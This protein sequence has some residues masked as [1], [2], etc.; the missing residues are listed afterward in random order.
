MTKFDDYFMILL[1][2]KK[3]AADLKRIEMTPNACTI[4]RFTAVI[5][6]YYVKIPNQDWRDNPERKNPEFW[7]AALPLPPLT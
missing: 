5:Y 2:K 1:R 6:W 4:K 3:S 7:E